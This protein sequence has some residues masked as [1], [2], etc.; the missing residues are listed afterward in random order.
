MESRKWQGKTAGGLFNKFLLI[1]LQDEK[2]NFYL[3]MHILYVF[4]CIKSDR[5]ISGLSKILWEM[6]P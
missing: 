3:F 5:W 4:C 2:I 1:I 6:K